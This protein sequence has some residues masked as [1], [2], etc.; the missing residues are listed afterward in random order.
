[1]Q[2]DNSDDG[3]EPASLIVAVQ[4]RR[5]RPGIQVWGALPLKRT[6][7]TCSAGAFDALFCHDD[8]EERLLRIVDTVPPV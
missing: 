8:D 2:R 3:C 5:V 6:G 7:L 4:V 1:M